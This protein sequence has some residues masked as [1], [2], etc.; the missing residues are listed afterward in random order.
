MFKHY[1]AAAWQFI[2][3]GLV[4]VP[5]LL[6][7]MPLVAIGLL[8]RRTVPGTL[9]PFTQHAPGDWELVRLPRLLL[10]WDNTVDGMLGDKRG[11]WNKQTGDCRRFLSMW[12]WAAIRNP[13]NYFK[14]FILTCD[15]RACRIVKLLGQ[16]YVRDDFNSTGAHLLLADNGRRRFYHLYFVRRWGKSK[17]AIV[18]QLGYKFRLGDESVIYSYENAR[19]AFKGFTFE[20]NPAKD[21]S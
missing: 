16:D 12:R 8:F 11:S 15:V 17:R 6:L 20:A 19:N 21:I 13:A 9:R 1:C 7:G 4:T 2:A 3:H 18:V 14:R 5:L 10:W